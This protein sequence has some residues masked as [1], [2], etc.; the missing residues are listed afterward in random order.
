MDIVVDIE[1][2][3]LRPGSV[4]FEIGAVKFERDGGGVVAATDWRVNVQSCL[5][6]GLTVGGSTLEFWLKRGVRFDLVEF[7]LSAALLDFSAW[8]GD[9]DCVWGHG[10]TFDISHLEAACH[11]CGL[12]VP[13]KYNKVRD[14]RTLF[15]VAGYTYKA[16][17]DHSALDD[18]RAE[19]VAIQK[20]FRLL[21]G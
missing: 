17:G 5:D 11:A 21:R 12:P 14:T 19:A 1:T 13:W 8:C 2:L 9:F 6:L 7:G 10:P 4:I 20:S 18:A 16:P 3:G 15:D